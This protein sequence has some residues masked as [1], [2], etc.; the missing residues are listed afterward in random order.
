MSWTP[1]ADIDQECIPL[2]EA[3]NALDGVETYACCCGHGERRFVIHFE[4]DESVREA[5]AASEALERIHG[6]LPVGG[7]WELRNANQ[8]DRPGRR[9]VEGPMGDRAYSESEEIAARL[10]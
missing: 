7:H 10:T 4:L 2:C 9:F 3:L 6:A 1:P 5:A 8:P